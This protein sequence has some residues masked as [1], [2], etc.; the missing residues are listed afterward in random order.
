MTTYEIS[1]SRIPIT[2]IIRGAN[3]LYVLERRLVTG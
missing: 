2:L 1:T 3:D